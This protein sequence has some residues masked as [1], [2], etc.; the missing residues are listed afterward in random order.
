MGD[1]FYLIL[2]LTED[3]MM[4]TFR[5][6]V[7]ST[8]LRAA[9]ELGLIINDTDGLQTALEFIQDHMPYTMSNE[10]TETFFEVLCAAIPSESERPLIF[11]KSNV[12][13][14]SDMCHFAVGYRRTRRWRNLSKA[15]G[16]ANQVGCPNLQTWPN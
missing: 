13:R 10:E 8:C 4:E 1:P 2:A 7:S 6:L 16:R 12:R 3:W 15:P 5:V 11:T 14:T 9:N